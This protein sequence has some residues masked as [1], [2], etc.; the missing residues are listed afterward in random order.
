MRAL[1]LEEWTRREGLGYEP[2]S[3]PQPLVSITCWDFFFS[4]LDYSR[5]TILTSLLVFSQIYVEVHFLPPFTNCGGCGWGLLFV[6]RFWSGD[7]PSLPPFSP[8]VNITCSPSEQR[9]PGF[10]K[11]LMFFSTAHPELKQ[12]QG[13]INHWGSDITGHSLDDAVICCFPLCSLT[14]LL[15]LLFTTTGLTLNRVKP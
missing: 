1:F 9:T 5:I 2:A 3:H 7:Y 4:M 15:L 11:F 12:V 14:L 13:L 6:C 10:F 8:L